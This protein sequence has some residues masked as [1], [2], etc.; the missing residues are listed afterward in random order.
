MKYT[1]KIAESTKDPKILTEILK[2]RKDDD[3]SQCAAQNINCP[4]EILT[5]VLKRGKN[6][7]VSRLAANNTNCTS[8]MLEEILERNIDDDVSMWASRNPKC[9]KDAK[10]KWLY[11][12]KSVKKIHDFLNKNTRSVS[13]LI[14]AQKMIE[15]TLKNIE[16]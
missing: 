1:A 13:L 10:R 7:I 5:E 3:I 12:I 14:K 6:D 8:E 9:P 11:N 2:M 4:P 15:K 16:K